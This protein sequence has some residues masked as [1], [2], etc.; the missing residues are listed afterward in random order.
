MLEEE[1]PV[2]QTSQN[3]LFPVKQE[4]IDEKE[5]ATNILESQKIDISYPSQW[6]AV[7]NSI[8]HQ[9]IDL[10]ANLQDDQLQDEEEQDSAKQDTLVHDTD[11][12]QDDYDSTTIDIIA[13]STTIQLGK[14][15]TELF[16]TDNVT[17]PN[18]KVGCVF[19]TIHLQKYLEE[20]PPSSDK[21]AFLDIYHMLSLL[22]RY[23]YDN[24]KQHTY[25][26]SPNNEYVALLKYA[27]HLH[28]DIGTFPTV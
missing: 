13:D 22:D 24:P 1:E 18:E 21:Q 8:S 28:V 5:S 10:D 3:N 4:F 26:M 20:Y 17:V 12:S 7:S 25:C 16:T 2:D 14:P 6:Q 11:V 9:G 27:I 15:V 19:V 23:L